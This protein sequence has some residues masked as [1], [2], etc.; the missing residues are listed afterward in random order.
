MPTTETTPVCPFKVGDRVRVKVGR[1]PL[2]KY[3]VGTVKRVESMPHTPG[4]WV[5]I[6][7]DGAAKS[8]RLYTMFVF[9]DG[10]RSDKIV[11][12]VGEQTVDDVCR[13]L[14][15]SVLEDGDLVA[16]RALADRLIEMCQEQP[17]P[18]RSDR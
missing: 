16:A 9:R 13:A 3:R 12:E 6:V 15:R 7:R 14:A 2:M 5:D 17:T 4:W 10:S 8:N 11:W 18:D 1:C